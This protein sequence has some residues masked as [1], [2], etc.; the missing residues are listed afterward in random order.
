M[1]TVD[2]YVFV[3]KSME[4]MI[5]SRKVIKRQY[6][7]FLLFVLLLLLLLHSRLRFPKLVLRHHV[8]GSNHHVAV[9]VVGLFDGFPFRLD[10]PLVDILVCRVVVEGD[11]GGISCY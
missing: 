3:S 8:V 5:L 7:K 1:E 9:V 10:S 11:A 6:D 2:Y 4:P